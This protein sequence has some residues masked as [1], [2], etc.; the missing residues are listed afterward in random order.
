MFPSIQT[1]TLLRFESRL[2]IKVHKIAEG[3]VIIEVLINSV[4]LGSPETVITYSCPVPSSSHL[5]C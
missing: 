1:E 2:K 5:G 4:I 3:R